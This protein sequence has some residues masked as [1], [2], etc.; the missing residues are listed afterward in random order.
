LGTVYIKPGSEESIDA[1]SLVS[2]KQLNCASNCDV[3]SG[4]LEER[5]NEVVGVRAVANRLSSV[6]KMQLPVLE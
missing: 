4:A 5:T 3:N 1:L 6:R 2:H